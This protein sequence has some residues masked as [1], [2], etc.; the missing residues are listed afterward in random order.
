METNHR[1]AQQGILNSLLIHATVITII[2]YLLVF[3]RLSLA[4]KAYREKAWPPEG[5]ELG[6]KV[7]IKVGQA[8]KEYSI[9]FA[10]L[11][12]LF[13]ISPIKWQYQAYSYYEQIQVLNSIEIKIKKLKQKLINCEP[14]K[15]L[16]KD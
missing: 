9:K 8:A 1:L 13:L 15:K 2:F 14:N 5:T 7:P 4:F 11:S 6:K 12:I 3:S 16:N 10:L